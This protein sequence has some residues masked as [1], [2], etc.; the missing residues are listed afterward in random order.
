MD[1]EQPTNRLF[2]TS[3][4]ISLLRLALTV[5]VVIT[6]LNKQ[7]I[8]AFVLCWAGA[9]TDWLDG[10]VARKTNTVSEWGKII[11]PFAD[12]VL[13]GAV[14]VMMFIQNLLPAWFVIAVIA[15]DIAIMAGAA[16]ARKRM[17]T[18]LP[19][20]M[21]GKLAVSAIALTGVVAMW[22]SGIA[23]DGLIMLSCALMALSLWDYAKRLHGLL[24]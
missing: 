2:T 6:L 15:R 23:R 16:I 5:P 1:T 7:Y 14:V 9:L 18:V 24:R 10:Y 20:L 4:V 3:N 12:K 13:V 21:S 17:K 22:T 19:S 11:D 8:V